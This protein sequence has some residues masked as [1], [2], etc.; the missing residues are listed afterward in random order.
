MTNKRDNFSNPGY[1]VDSPP[2]YTP[3]SSSQGATEST[4]VYTDA[5][6]NS[7]SAIPTPVYTPPS[8]QTQ[9]SPE[10]VVLTAAIPLNNL[11]AEPAVT[12][13]PHCN[14]VVLSSTDFRAGSATW[15]SSFALF[16]FGITSWGCCLFPFCISDLKDCIHSCPN[17]GRIMA[18]YSRLDGK[19]YKY[20]GDQFE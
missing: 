12:T 18:K 13:C 6:K 9:S 14:H 16:L 5:P 10:T 20:L 7:Y 19:V 3:S 8:Q 4:R 1:T 2:P 11:R 15:L 17:C